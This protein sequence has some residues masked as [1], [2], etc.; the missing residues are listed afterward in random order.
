MQNWAMQF[1]KHKL[2]FDDRTAEILIKQRLGSKE[3]ELLR[4]FEKEA[5]IRRDYVRPILVML[6]EE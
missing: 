2:C 6:D 5:R 3:N 4:L 1:C